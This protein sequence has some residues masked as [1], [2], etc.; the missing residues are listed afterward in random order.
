MCAADVGDLTF[1]FSVSGAA[2]AASFQESRLGRGGN[3]LFRLIPL[4]F[5]AW[6]AS[7]DCPLDVPGLLLLLDNDLR[8]R[9]QPR[10][11]ALCGG[12]TADESWLTFVFV[13]RREP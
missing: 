5:F 13:V 6:S 10:Q 12:S 1:S 8:A 3:S 4:D 9:V 7:S 2:C 11:P